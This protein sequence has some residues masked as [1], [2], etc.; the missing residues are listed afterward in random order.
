MTDGTHEERNLGWFP[1]ER[2]DVFHAAL[3]FA[4]WVR[5]VRSRIPRAKLRGQLEEA[6]ESIVL[7]I[8]EAAGRSGGSRRHQFEIA[9][10]SAAECHGAVCLCRI[11]G[12]PNTEEALHLLHRIRRML[13]GLHRP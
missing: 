1:H 3:E 7:N 12:V 13:A 5:A 8:C 11:Y 9:Y 4:G 2:L 6:A 10:G